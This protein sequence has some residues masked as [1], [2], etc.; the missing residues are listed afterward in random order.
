MLGPPRPQSLSRPFVHS[1]LI[2]LNWNLNPHP[3]KSPVEAPAT[4]R[5]R[6][7]A[8]SNM[9]PLLRMVWQT[10]PAITTSTVLLRLL[11]AIVPVA[12]LWTG[13]LIMDQVG[14]ALTGLPRDPQRIWVLLGYEIGLVVFSDLLARAINLCDSLLG[15]KFTNFVS[16]RLME[17]A[18][19][20]D[21]VSFED[22][23]FYDKLDRARRQT[24]AR[25]GM[26]AVLAGM[27]QQLITLLSLSAAVVSFSPWFLLLLVVAV[28][29]AFLGE[30][31]FA[32]LAY[33]ML[34]RWTPERRE[35]DYLR[36]LGASSQSAKEV[37]IFGLGGYLAAQTDAEHY[38]SER[39]REI[40]ETV[41]LADVETEE[42]AK[43][44]REYGLTEAEM[45]P[46]VKAI[47]SDQKSWVDF[48]MRFELGLEEPDPTRANR[49]AVTIALSYVFGGLIPL[50]PYMIQHD[51]SVALWYSVGI[52]LLALGVFGF[53]KGRFTGIHPLKGAVQTV[54]IGGI[55]AAA[56]F[57]L[58]KLVSRS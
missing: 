39:E 23:V 48:M 9:P 22:P 26:L 12:Q 56:A 54:V 28:I 19:Q 43:V 47:T 36:M 20:L 49:S 32:M 45:A 35:L 8:L 7:R 18:S 37:K 27:G 15:D 5:D 3:P 55:A 31:R 25:L 6:I 17:H 24:T 16:L 53:V 30:T 1:R 51:V 2:T 14:R 29:P 11:A 10:S 41:E 42:V 38:A 57:G 34:Y 50:A 44:F 46:V 21:L 52:T 58:A 13:K 33:S 4:W 40:R